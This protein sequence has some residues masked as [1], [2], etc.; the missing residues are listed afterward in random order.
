MSLDIKRI[1][2]RC[3]EE[4]PQNGKYLRIN[5]GERTNKIDMVYALQVAANH[6]ALYPVD[7]FELAKIAEMNCMI[8]FMERGKKNVLEE[9]ETAVLQA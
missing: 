5:I 4:I 7:S 9:A 2:N 1:C 6:E 3:G 8:V